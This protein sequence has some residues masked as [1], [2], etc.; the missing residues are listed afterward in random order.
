MTSASRL[1]RS[2]T[3]PLRKN[4]GMVMSKASPHTT[5]SFTPIDRDLIRPCRFDCKTEKS[6]I[7]ALHSAKYFVLQ[8]TTTK[9]F[10]PLMGSILVPN[11]LLVHPS[12]LWPRLELLARAWRGIQDNAC[13]QMT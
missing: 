12:F 8:S 2:P 11:S 4:A 6:L 5:I 3:N 1:V 7:C 13:D 9:K 10:M